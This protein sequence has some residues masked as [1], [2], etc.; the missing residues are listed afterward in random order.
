MNGPA[1]ASGPQSFLRAAL[2]YAR[3]GWRVFPLW[4]LRYDENTDTLVCTCKKGRSC[5]KNSGKHPRVN[6]W[7]EV[8]TTDEGKI[9]AWWSG[10]REGSNVGIALGEVRGGALWVLDVDGAKGEEALT[11]LPPLPPTYEVKTGN[12]RHLFYQG[13]TDC[14]PVAL[15]LDVRGRGGYVVA[16]PSLHLSGRTYTALGEAPIAEL[17]REALPYFVASKQEGRGVQDPALLAPEGENRRPQTLDNNE[18]RVKGLGAGPPNPN[19]AAYSSAR[20]GAICA[21]ARAALEVGVDEVAGQPAGGRATR[22]NAVSYRLG[23]VIAGGALSRGEVEQQLRA[24]ALGAADPL[25]EGQVARDLPASLDAGER[26]PHDFAGIG[27]RAGASRQRKVEGGRGG[28]EAKGEAKEEREEEGREPGQDDD[29]ELDPQEA[30]RWLAALDAERAKVAE[31]ERAGAQAE[32]AEAE[33]PAAAPAPAKAQPPKGERG[34]RRPTI[35]LQGDLEDQSWQMIDLV[36]YI[37]ERAPSLFWRG[38]QM[39]RVVPER[40]RETISM[41]GSEELRSVLGESF[42]FASPGEEGPED[43]EALPR[44]LAV[45]TMTKKR[46]L[47]LPQLEEV[48]LHPVY[49]RAGRLVAESGYH[50]SLSAWLDLGDQPAPYVPEQ[51]TSEDLA[52]AR[53]L[54]DRELLG[55]FPWEDGGPV[56]QPDGTTKPA[57]DE[58]ASLAHAVALGLLPFVRPM[59]DG[60]TPLHLISAPTPGTGKSYLA[61]CLAKVSGSKYRVFAPAGTEEEWRKRISTILL[62]APGIV[63]LDNLSQ[64][65]MLDSASLAA[66]LTG[67]RWSDRLMGTMEPL[68]LEI[69]CGWVATANGPKLT[70]ELARRSVWIPLNARMADPTRRAFSRRLDEWV[71]QERV[72]LQQAFLLLVQHW[73][74]KGRPA[75]STVNGSYP[76]WSL[77]MG[78]ILEAAGYSGFAANERRMKAAIDGETGEWQG[79][80]ECWWAAH[81]ERPVGVRELYELA[82]NNDLLMAVFGGANEASAKVRLAK[83]LGKR[84]DMVFE[85]ETPKLSAQI[86]AGGSNANKHA[87]LYKLKRQEAPKAT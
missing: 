20:W 48:L 65:D 8:A 41:V 33:P 19:P 40:G 63:Q 55:E 80:V 53:N 18:A 11:K 60:P 39:V 26:N 32:Q 79:F 44:S 62:E 4:G 74:C 82:V 71:E 43:M 42:R 30:A 31:A 24:A 75:P 85:M 37:N 16:A 78:G 49:D 3:R 36:D 83:A 35:I 2:D 47:R 50:P 84:L 1:V 57:A 25:P 15:G 12:G 34:K 58:G 51:P 76:A 61:E 73:I 72:Q 69:R 68:D 66:V 13:L 21:W 77:V 27:E 86:Q 59:I 70:K 29:R 6:D 52:W 87:T 17:S 56:R 22:L 9:R 10:G 14:R 5:G 46:R 81:D 28:K 7:D 67:R 23:R 54:I 45:Y 64:N 38:P